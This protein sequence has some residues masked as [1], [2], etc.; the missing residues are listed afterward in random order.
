MHNSLS[1][2]YSCCNNVV[3]KKLIKRGG[4]IQHKG[5][6][7]GLAFSKEEREFMKFYTRVR[8]SYKFLLEF[9]QRYIRN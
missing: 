4:H 3:Y 2:V 8:I 7:F 5:K 6:E 1:A 9:Q